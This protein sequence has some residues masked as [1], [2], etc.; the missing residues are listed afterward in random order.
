[1]GRLLGKDERQEVWWVE[2]KHKDKDTGGNYSINVHSYNDLNLEHY[3]KTLLNKLKDTLEITGFDIKD[4]HLKIID[5]TM[6][7]TSY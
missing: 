1:M 5:K 6:P 7:I 4:M 3:K 2:T